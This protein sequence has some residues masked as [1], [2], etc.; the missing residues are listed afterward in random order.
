MNKKKILTLG[1]VVVTIS[2]VLF[3]PSGTYVSAADKNTTFQLTTVMQEST[4]IHHDVETAEDIKILAS[5]WKNFM[6]KHPNASEKKQE[7]FLKEF[8]RTQGFRTT[9]TNIV[10]KGAGDYLP[11]YNNLNKEEKKLAKKHPLQA[12]KVY[13]CAE[14]ATNLT[15]DYYGINGYQDNSDAFRHCCWN[16]LMK[17][18]IGKSAAKAWADAHETESS[19]V[20]KEMDLY[21]NSV[22]RGIEVDGKSDD[23]IA[24][25]VKSKVKKG[26]CKKI[27]NGKL[28]KTDGSGLKK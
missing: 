22:G 21:N 10:D 14:K 15:I 24:K 11:G 18:S 6:K 7:A 16:A 23:E 20:D 3:Q 17:K 19:G 2:G 25:S 8:Q 4:S 12:V 5:A 9:T 27:S 28:V 26:K 1:L 13:L